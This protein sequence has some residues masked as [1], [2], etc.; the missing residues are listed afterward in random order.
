MN[1]LQ[2]QLQLRNYTIKSTFSGP[3][4]PE[5]PFL[6]PHTLQFQPRFFPSAHWYTSPHI[7]KTSAQG[8]VHNP[9]MAPRPLTIAAL[10]T[11]ILAGFTLMA[12]FAYSSPL[13]SPATLHNDPTMSSGNIP[14]AQIIS[15]CGPTLPTCSTS[16]PGPLNIHTDPG[17]ISTH[18]R[19][20]LTNST[21]SN[22]DSQGSQRGPS[23]SSRS[24]FHISF[25]LIQAEY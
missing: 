2:L 3:Q 4:S 6:S 15:K 10:L 22:I 13:P 14:S 25:C 19:Q 8:P 9:R 12:L 7:M 1:D 20:K 17:L 23:G 16:H 5:E 21:H 18:N 11:I 24:S